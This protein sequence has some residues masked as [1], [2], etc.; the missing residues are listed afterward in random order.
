LLYDP[1]TTDPATY[2]RT[3]F[4][5][6]RI[7][8]SRESPL[9]KALFA[10]SPVPTSAD[11]PLVASNFTAPAITNQTVPNI[12]FRLDH[13]VDQNNRIY[14]RYTSVNQSQATLR[15][16][17]SNTAAS[18]AGAGLTA[19]ATGFQEIP[20][21]TYSGALGYTHV[22]SP[23][24]FSESI[25]SQQWFSQYFNGG[26]ASNF[27][28]EQ[29]LGLPNNFGEL[30]FPTIS[31]TVMPYGGTQFNYGISQ[32]LSN[33]DENLT[34][35]LGRHQLQFGGR[36]RHERFGYLPDRSPDQVNFGAYVTG[37]INPA[38]GANYTALP[39]TGFADG[40]MFLGAAYNYTATLNP[41]YQHY[42]LQEIDSYFQDN[43]HVN[44]NLTINAGIRWEIHPAPY[45]EDGLLESFDPKNKAIVLANPLSFYINKSYTNLTIIT[46]LQNLGMKFETPQQAGIPDSMF[47][48]NNLAF[49]PRIGVAY[50][51]FGGK[52]GTVLRAGCCGYIYPAPIRNSVKITAPNA[53]F[54]TSYSRSYINANQ[55]PDGLPNYL[56]R[57]PQT[58][59]AGQ[60]SSS[61]V[62]SGTTNSILPGINL[63][64]LNPEYPPD[65]VTQVNATIEQPLKGGSVFRITYMWNHGEGL[66]QEC[67]YNNFPSP[68]VWETTT[69]TVAPN[70]RRCRSRTW[71][72]SACSAASF[73]AS[74]PWSFSSSGLQPRT[75][76]NWKYIKFSKMTP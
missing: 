55:S 25:V 15:N 42:R 50:T 52:Y 58:T 34:K 24:F 67:F 46:N 38:S 66:D 9:A 68:Y 59:V 27:N 41:A 30:G 48:N 43:F 18:V 26:P 3:P 44:R 21:A 54:S 60:N 47:S 29:T 51:P 61:V 40:D 64:T 1:A 4:P 17:P 39:N 76:L 63:T 11:N 70:V 71:T 13:I 5:N 8:E 19:N 28:V 57:A 10:I 37:N 33:I 16:Y 23:T 65:F 62:N 14:L 56:L 69:G 75:T 31:G 12:T 35:V 32:I 22:F 36:Y 53:P 45:T 2:Q 6:N 72:S 73:S 49:S 74:S 20:I 7:P